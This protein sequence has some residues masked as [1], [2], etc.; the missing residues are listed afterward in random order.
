MSEMKCSKCQCSVRLVKNA[1]KN[2]E[3]T[4]PRCHNRFDSGN[5]RLAQYGGGGPGAGASSWSPG[6][7]PMGNVSQSGSVNAPFEDVSLDAMMP[8]NNCQN[9]YKSDR[10]IESRLEPFHQFR[11]KDKIPYELTPKQRQK[12]KIKEQIRRREESY[13]DA[14]K[15]IEENS[16]AFIEKYFKPKK[17]HMRT[18]EDSLTHNREDEKEIEIKSK[19]VF[20]EDEKD[21]PQHIHLAFKRKSVKLNG[22]RQTIFDNPDESDEENLDPLVSTNK[23]IGRTQ[24]DGYINHD[25]VINSQEDY[26]DTAGTSGDHSANPYTEYGGQ[27]VNSDS[28]NGMFGNTESQDIGQSKMFVA[29]LPSM[30]TN[31]NINSP[32]LTTEQ[33]MEMLNKPKPQKLNSPYNGHDL[34]KERGQEG[35]NSMYPDQGDIWGTPPSL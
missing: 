5:K 20:L 18:M 13:G 23:Q 25:P 15:S 21:A 31:K 34:D 7:S 30:N 8:R 26:N 17:E 24:F 22:P 35:V 6:S 27:G 1:N 29:N 9:D 2:N 3:Y 28:D 32:F 11:E 4:C 10:S 14:V 19:H 16:P 12:E 33:K